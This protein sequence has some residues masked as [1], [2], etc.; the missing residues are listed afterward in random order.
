VDERSEVNVNYDAELVV[1]GAVEEKVN[2]Q[3]GEKFS[4][5][6]AAFRRQVMDRELGVKINRDTYIGLIASGPVADTLHECRVGQK[7]Y[8]S[9]ELYRQEFTHKDGNPGS[10]R[11]L[12]L[13]SIELRSAP[14]LAA[15]GASVL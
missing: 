9:G 14:V 1:L 5:C 10:D 3:T 11:K 8:V 12:N 6:R 13:A 4:V 7:V 15:G 2:T